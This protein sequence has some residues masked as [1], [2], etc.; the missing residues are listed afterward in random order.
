MEFSYNLTSL[1]YRPS[2]YLGDG[3]NDG[4]IIANLYIDFSSIDKEYSESNARRFE[5]R[6][7][8]EYSLDCKND[9]L[10]DQKRKFSL[11]LADH[12]FYS[13]LIRINTFRLALALNGTQTFSCDLNV[14]I[15]GKNEQKDTKYGFNCPRGLFP[16][17]EESQ[18]WCGADFSLNFSSEKLSTIRGHIQMTFK[19]TKEK[20]LGGLLLYDTRVFMENFLSSFHPFNLD[21]LEEDFEIICHGEKVKFNS[22]VL[23]KISPAF[24]AML[25]NPLMKSI[26]S[27]TGS[28]TMIDTTPETIQTFKDILTKNLLIETENARSISCELLKFADKYDIALLYKF[29]EYF[30]GTSLNKETL[31]E[32]IHV[33]YLLENKK[34]LSRAAKFAKAMIGSRQDYIRKWSKFGQDNPKCFAKFTKFMEKEEF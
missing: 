5:F 28:V 3:K 15:N 27:I 24:H 17:L 11:D 19:P 18:T 31:A 2:P 7:G 25:E 12:G 32:V 33:A 21:E 30:L 6:K 9:Q 10:V 8:D 13:C 20:M 14:L 1:D 26:E 23:K 16:T 4:R 34:L 22:E 29:C